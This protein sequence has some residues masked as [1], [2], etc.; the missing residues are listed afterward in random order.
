MIMFQL[1]VKIGLVWDDAYKM[2][3]NCYWKNI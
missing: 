3:Y 2:F 1:N